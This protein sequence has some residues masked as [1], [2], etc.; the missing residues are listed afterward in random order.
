M[1]LNIVAF[2]FFGAWASVGWYVS[3]AVY[4]S[5]VD[6]PDL[7]ARP[8]YPN[9]ALL[10]ILMVTLT[11]FIQFPGGYFAGVA[12]WAVTAFGC[13][14]LSTTRAAILFAYLAIGSLV[15]RLIV[16]GIMEMFFGG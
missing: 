8:D 12:I 4:K 15:S 9:V 2:V 7:T 6:D 13:L 11:S 16:L 10:A 3:V 1:L 5:T 14:G